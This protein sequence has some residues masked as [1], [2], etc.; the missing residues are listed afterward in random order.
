MC[1]GANQSV[2]ESCYDESYYCMPLLL[3]K[4]S[5]VIKQYIIKTQIIFLTLFLPQ[6]HLQTQQQATHNLTSM[7][8]HVVRTQG[9]L[10]LYNGLSASLMRQVKR[11]I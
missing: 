4:L 5:Q 1:S 11:C 9:V 10:A 8:I 6:V 3:N 2:C 7:G